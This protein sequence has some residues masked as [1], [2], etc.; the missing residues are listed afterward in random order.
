[1]IS[2]SPCQLDVDRDTTFLPL[3]YESLLLSLSCTLLVLFWSLWNTCKFL[4]YRVRWTVSSL[5]Q[6]PRHR[7]PPR[8]P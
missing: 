4:K 1:M 2:P 6:F 7:R 8:C 5:D 3:S